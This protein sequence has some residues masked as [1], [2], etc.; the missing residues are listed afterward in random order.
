MPKLCINYS[1]TIIYRIVCKD[2]KIIDCYVGSTTDFKS[3][4]RQHKSRCNNLNDTGYNIYVYCFI[5][6][7]GGWDNWDI[8]EVE[9]YNAIDKLD[10]SKKERYWLEYYGATL[11][12]KV[13]SKTSQEYYNEHKEEIII[14][15]RDYTSTRKDTI[16]EYNK[17]YREKNIEKIKELAKVYSSNN[18]EKL[19]KYK[20]DYYLKNKVIA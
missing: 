10:Q 20:H 19:K 13:P 9:K 11:N 18:K 6:E 4:K 7:N 16:Q 8:I 1:K 2:P 17:K 5:R 3:R 15:H 14:Q 12:I